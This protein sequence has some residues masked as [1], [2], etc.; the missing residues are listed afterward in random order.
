MVHS[1]PYSTNEKMF[2]CLG[3][4]QSIIDLDPV[5]FSELVKEYKNLPSENDVNL[6][7][8]FESQGFN[9]DGYIIDQEGITRYDF[10]TNLDNPQTMGKNER[11][12]Y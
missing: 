6:L 10:Q 9:I 1:H 8:E 4:P 11:C 2:A 7:K 12:G 5:G 3:I